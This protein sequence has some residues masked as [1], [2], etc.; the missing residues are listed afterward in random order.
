MHKLILG[1]DVGNYEGKTVG[2][3]GID[4]WKTNI[5]SMTDRKVFEVYGEDDMEFEFRGRTGLAGTI[6]KYE[7]R[8]G[9]KSMYGSSKAHWYT[10]IRVLLSI[11]RYTVKY[12]IKPDNV[13]I[14]TG[15]P[16]IGHTDTDKKALKDMLVGEHPIIVNGDRMIINIEEVGIAPEGVGA[17][18]SMTTPPKN[19]KV[20]DIG[21]GTINAISFEDYR[22]TNFNSDTFNYGTEVMPL[23][24]VVESVI[25]DTTALGWSVNERIYVCGG[26]A[27]E[28]TQYIKKHYTNVEVLTP[29]LA[30]KVLAPKFANAAGYYNLAL[31][32]FR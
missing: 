27:G 11:Y 30:G 20:L 19:G 25:Q 18:F 15:Q 17:Y 32:T 13:S 29:T 9:S 23:M 26:S 8:R 1:D 12:G 6:A 2:P 14:V 24:E 16:Y 3:H 21:S 4:V 22:V 10:Q 7:S 31:G 5:S 28:I